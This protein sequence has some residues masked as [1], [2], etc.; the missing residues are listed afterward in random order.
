MA[1]QLT[2]DNFEQ[3]VEK[4]EGTV[5]V[6]FW[7][8]WCG[9]CMMISPIIEEISSEME[10]NTNVKIVKVNVD[11]CSKTATKYQVMSIPTMIIF[12][13]GKVVDTLVGAMT[14]HVYTEA[15]KK[16]M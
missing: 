9:P 16:H 3:E 5:L 4:F 15:L 12:Q 13:K 7:A 6:D 11:S 1:V 14:K 8:S 2:D 10:G